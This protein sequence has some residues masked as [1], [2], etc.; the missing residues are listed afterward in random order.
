MSTGPLMNALPATRGTKAAIPFWRNP[1][2]RDALWQALLIAVVLG[3][4]VWLARNA[5]RAL[6]ERGM[7]S[8]FGFLGAAANFAIGDAFFS[9]T[10][11]STYYNAFAVGIG[12][13]L[14][15][16]LVSIVTATAL[17]GLLGFARLSGN[18]LVAGLAKA[19]VEAFRNTPQL[20]QI[21]FWYSF[22]V[23]L[24]APR[25]SWSLLGLGYASNRGLTLPSPDEP[26]VA[27]MVLSMLAL[28]GVATFALGRLADRS[29][30]RTGRRWI[31]LPVIQGAL[32]LLP[33]VLAWLAAGAPTGWSVPALRGFNYAGGVT[34]AP[35]LLAIYFGLSFY[36]AAFIAEIVRG[37]LLSVDAG[38]IEAA[39]AIGLR[40]AD[41]YRKVMVPQALRVVVPPLAAQYI[42]LLKNSSLG[43]AIGYPDLF[44]I[45]NT[46]L[47]YSG[48]T[49][50][51]LCI[52]ALTYLLMSLAIGAIANLINRVVQIP[53]R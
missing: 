14:V 39:Q 10:P 45:S 15:L 24:P 46:A 48:R 28:G 49:I 43:V 53:E 25:Q 1:R 2:I 31:F 51:V 50:E 21:V 35:E 33:A 13:T 29:R 40:R 37:G 6:D 5:S 11:G 26:G 16:S 7:A 47:T 42:S 23:L 36:I 30:R 34:L 19:Y 44:S 41:L 32:F 4:I 38:Q 52:M 3:L 27:L 22:I 17:G 18:A 20:V 12:N 8:G 9:F